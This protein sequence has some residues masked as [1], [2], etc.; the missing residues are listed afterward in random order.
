MHDQCTSNLASLIPLV[1]GLPIRFT[2]SISKEYELYRGRTGTL[3]GWTED[4]EAQDWEENGE[5]V[6]DKLP[7]VLYV[8]FPGTDIIIDG[9][10]TG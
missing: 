6:M 7:L 4:P 9:L 2:D 3:H 5:R 10:A 1:K 8:D